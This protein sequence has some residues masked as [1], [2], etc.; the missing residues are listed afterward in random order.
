VGLPREA[1]HV[2][3]DEVLQALG[4]RGIVELLVEGGG[5]VHGAFLDARA[6]DAVVCYIAPVIVGGRDA[7]SAFGGVG[8]GS[9]ADA[10]RLQD[11]EVERVGPDLKVSAEFAHVHRDH[12]GDR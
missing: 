9:L 8:A 4:R 10:H 6:A 1:G 2:P 12:H 5:A 11:V 7:F 3:I